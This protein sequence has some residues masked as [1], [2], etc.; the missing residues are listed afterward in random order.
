MFSM[1]PLFPAHA[2][3]GAQI[4]LRKVALHLAQQGHTITILCTR[5]SAEHQPFRWH[6]N[7]EVL[8]LLRFKQPYPEP[9]ATTP[10]HIA[11]AIRDVGEYLRRADR[12]YS[13]DGGLIFPYVY[14]FEHVPTI[15]SYRSVLFAETL[16]S[17]FLFQGDALI[18]PSRYARDVYVASAGQSFPGYAARTQVIYNGMDWDVFKPTAPADI[19]RYLPGID[20]A[21]HACLLYP[22]RPEAPK[23]ILHVIE[24]ADRLVNHE[25]LRH[26]RVLVPRWIESALSE[27]DRA[28]Y[29]RLHDAISARGLQEQFVF[30]DWLPEALMPQYYSMGAAT[31]CL[32]SYVETFGNVPYESLG[33]G[34]PAVLARV[35]PAREILP[36]ALVDKV[37]YG[38]VAGAAAALARIIQDGERTRPETLAYLQM[39]LAQQQMVEAY[40]EVILHA[41]RQPTLDYRLTPRAET[42]VFRIAPWCYAAPQGIYNDFTAAYTVDPTLAALSG[43]LAF[44]AADAAQADLQR[45]LQEGLCVPEMWNSAYLSLG[46]NHMPATHL[47]RAVAALREQFV[48]LAVS[49]VYE[50]PATGEAEGG[51]PYLNA[52]VLLATHYDVRALKEALL[53]LE[54]TL[55]R[56]RSR[57]AS[58]TI[59]LDIALF[60]DQ[61]FSSEFLGRKRPIPD[62]AV[63]HDAYVLVPLADIAPVYRHPV[64]GRTL[65][66]LAAPHRGTLRLRED[67]RFA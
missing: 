64:E 36:D 3:G 27:T 22:H 47:P 54:T 33:C 45:W 46:S 15:I 38:D 66:A 4:Q 34:T 7:A 51:A 50:S 29:A 65:A 12:F 35:G 61:Q 9:Y 48:V 40:A 39:H 55:G 11:N 5:R 49:P 25:G 44:S 62:P 16:Q 56:D 31:L 18:L 24:V 10:Y 2:M 53:V 28:F 63:L 42:S 14:Q 17:G 37:D 52:A 30:H 67:V 8:P 59:D 43:R 26:I 6:E 1:T 13:H 60:N 57:K 21:Q 20:P 41:Q 23:G 19:L 32:G 58:V